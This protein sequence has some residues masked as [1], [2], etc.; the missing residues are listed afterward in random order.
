[1]HVGFL[2][3]MYSY[4][5][6]SCRYLLT[7]FSFVYSHKQFSMLIVRIFFIYGTAKYMTAVHQVK[8]PNCFRC[9]KFFFYIAKCV[10]AV[11][12]I[13]KSEFIIGHDS[14]VLRDVTAE[15]KKRQILYVNNLFIFFI[16]TCTAVSEA[17]VSNA[18]PP[19]ECCGSS[20]WLL[21][22]YGTQ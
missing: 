10:R 12:G 9:Y 20:L 2:L 17:E 4:L 14:C 16:L 13:I 3:V 6:G 15:Q 22:H 1:M 18:W 5:S 19:S 11:K 7:L 21:R 8:I